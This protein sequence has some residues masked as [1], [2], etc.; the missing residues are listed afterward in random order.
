M[1]ASQKIC[2][3]VL[4]YL[5]GVL[6]WSFRDDLQSAP[7]TPVLAEETPPQKLQR[8]PGND[9]EVRRLMKTKLESSQE[10]LS[11]L[12]REDF[13]VLD[14][15]GQKLIELSQ[16]AAWRVYETPGYRQDSQ[17]FREHAQSLVQSAREKKLGDCTEAYIKIVRSCVQCHEHVRSY[18]G[19][20]AHPLQ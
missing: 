8:T 11:A 4:V 12:T 19:H 2:L 10:I 17:E 3:A 13:K 1:T 5:L 7:A 14:K 9:E 16:A 6:L 18:V 20:E 15:H